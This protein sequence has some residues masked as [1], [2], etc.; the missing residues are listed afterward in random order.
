MQGRSECSAIIPRFI[1]GQKGAVS[2]I[3]WLQREKQKG[4]TLSVTSRKP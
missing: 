4:D 2:H 1:L 3:W